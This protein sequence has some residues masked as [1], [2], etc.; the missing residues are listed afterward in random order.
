M[1]NCLSANYTGRL[2]IFMR[3]GVYE[4]FCSPKSADDTLITVTRTVVVCYTVGGKGK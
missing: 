1:T 3:V 4:V 2:V